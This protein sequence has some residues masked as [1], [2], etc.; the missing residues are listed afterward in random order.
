MV[1]YKQIWQHYRFFEL[2]MRDEAVTRGAEMMPPL[3]TM[4]VE[5]TG[6]LRLG[7]TTL[8]LHCPRK[9]VR[10]TALSPPSEREVVATLGS[11]PF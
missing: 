9:G 5:G 10:K 2:D 3:K 4:R 6:T 7:V 1:P 11:S 8:R